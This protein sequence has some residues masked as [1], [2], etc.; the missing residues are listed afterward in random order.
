M[1][2]WSIASD[3]RSDELQGSVSS[4]L[5]LSFLFD[6]NLNNIYSSVTSITCPSVLPLVELVFCGF[7]PLNCDLKDSIIETL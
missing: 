7:E 2:E 1:A 6:L 5:T 3:L 4:N